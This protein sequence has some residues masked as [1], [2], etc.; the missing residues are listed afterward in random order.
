MKSFKQ[1]QQ[2]MAIKNLGSRV[3]ILGL[4]SR[5]CDLL[6]VC[7][8]SFSTSPEVPQFLAYKMCHTIFFKELLRESMS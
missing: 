3:R 2:N 5:L 4:V 6:A 8:E 1:R 7:L